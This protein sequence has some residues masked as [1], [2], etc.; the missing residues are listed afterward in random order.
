MRLADRGTQARVAG[1]EAFNRS[2]HPRNLFDADRLAG[3]STEDI[4]NEP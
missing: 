1:I 3:C 4:E 2:H